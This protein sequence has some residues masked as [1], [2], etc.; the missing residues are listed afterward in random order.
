MKPTRFVAIPVLLLVGLAACNKDAPQEAA[1]SADPS[2]ATSTTA[3]ATVPGQID[4][5]LAPGEIDVG[6]T[7][8]SGPVY[9]PASDSI[10]Y[11]VKVRNNGKAGLVSAGTNPVN[12]GVVI[13]DANRSL[14]APPANHDFMRVSLPQALGTG[15]EITLP[16]S[17]DAE[18]TLGGIVVLDGVQEN[19]SWFSSYGKPVLTLGQFSRCEGES[20]TLCTEDGTRVSQVE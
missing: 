4:A 7:I 16:I 5:P 3:Q 9:D 11:Q 8:V 19:V 2:G 6:Y 15:D 13:W 10:S 18:P 14:K 12:F 17:F 20:N 1:P